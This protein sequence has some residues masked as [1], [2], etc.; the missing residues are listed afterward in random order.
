M[1][2]KHHTTSCSLLERKAGV[3]RFRRAHPSVRMYQIF[4]PWNVEL[5]RS[6]NS[7]FFWAGHPTFN[8]EI[9]IKWVCKPLPLGW[10]VYPLLYGKNGSLYISAH[11]CKNQHGVISSPFSPTTSGQYATIFLLFLVGGQEPHDFPWINPNLRL[12][13]P[14]YSLPFGVFRSR[15]E[16]SL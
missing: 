15:R 9:L 5:C 13:F 3:R 7:Q 10:W 16:R 12:G 11:M 4:K 14:Y 1:Q 6:K 8:A 2:K